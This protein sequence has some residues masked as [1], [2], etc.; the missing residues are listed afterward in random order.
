M[1]MRVYG[2]SCSCSSPAVIKKNDSQTTVFRHCYDHARQRQSALEK[3]LAEFTKSMALLQV[4][5]LFNAPAPDTAKL[6]MPCLNKVLSDLRTERQ[7][8]SRMRMLQA[9]G[10][11]TCLRYLE[12]IRM[13]VHTKGWSQKSV[14]QFFVFRC[15]IKKRRDTLSDRC[16]F[17]SKN[18]NCPHSSF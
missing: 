13:Y 1:I 4:G 17:S 16:I 8:M 15:I 14:A 6:N 18:H 7:V 9:H 11:N 3:K 12:P 5:K 10:V 2:R